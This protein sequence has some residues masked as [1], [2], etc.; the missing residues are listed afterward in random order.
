M[1]VAVILAALLRRAEHGP[2]ADRALA[3]TASTREMTNHLPPEV[4]ELAAGAQPPAP[5]PVPPAVPVRAAA[6]STWP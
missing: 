5:A 1:A 2:T 4:T 6:L 3:R